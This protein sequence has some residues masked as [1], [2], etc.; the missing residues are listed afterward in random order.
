MNLFF[1]FRACTDQLCLQHNGTQHVACLRCVFTQALSEG[2]NRSASTVYVSVTNILVLLLKYILLYL[3]TNILFLVLVVKYYNISVI[4]K[5][6]I[7][8]MLY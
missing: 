8:I 1:F 4:V 7:I 3:K 2:G 5:I 6:Y